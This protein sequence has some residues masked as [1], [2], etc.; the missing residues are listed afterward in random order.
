MIKSAL[1]ENED[2]NKESLTA[3]LFII[4]HRYYGATSFPN[5]SCKDC[6]IPMESTGDIAFGDRSFPEPNGRRGI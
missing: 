1:S 4:F 3:S 6:V 2:E 5:S